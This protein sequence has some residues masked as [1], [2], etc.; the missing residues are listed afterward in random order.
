MIRP[1]RK[2]TD[3]I[4]RQTT[5]EIVNFDLELETL[6]DDMVETMRQN[7]GIGL[8]APQVG[9]SQKVLVCEFNGDK[10]AKLPSFPLTVLCNPNITKSSKEEVNMVEGCLSFPGMEI[11]VKRPRE[12]TIAAKDRYGKEITISAKGY[13][14]RAI[15]HEIDH[16]NAT[17]LPDHLQETDLIFVGT[18]DLG[19]P[20]LLELAK[21]PQFKVKLVVTGKAEVTSRTHKDNVNL[22]KEIAK[23]YELPLIETENINN[24]TIIAKIKAL[25]P[26]IG[27][28]A[29]FGQLIKPEILNLFP[30]GL[31]N[32]HPSL[33][34]RHRGPSP[35]Q[36]T[37][38]EGDKEAG[39]TLMLTANKMDA[40][41]VI[42][43][44]YVNLRGSET[45]TILKNF[46]AKVAADQLLNILPYF[47]AG[48]LKTVAQD[49]K[50]VTFSHLFKKEDGFVDEKTPAVTVERKIRAFDSWPKVF[51]IKN[52]KRIQLL[53][54]HFNQDGDLII[55]RVKPE[56]KKE[57]S[58]ADF[59]R[60]YRT[61]LTFKG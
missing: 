17:L 24:P 14:A 46:L 29:D 27:V 39:V 13:Y 55:D 38:L 43:Q 23:K 58:Y 51:T 56:G 5:S 33:L 47:L 36:Q 2:T 19:V 31:I 7:N 48:D 53:A 9:V 34:P 16:L 61:T 20:A 37:I 21:S 4:L 52:G 15:Q 45:T 40:G 12:V 28:M 30:L 44:T 35:V 41:D 54:A 32:I 59:I 11:L 1:I 49:E 6:I 50:E 18:G 42:A 26:K 10:E 22:I 8:A 3:P 60:G 25:K 57:M